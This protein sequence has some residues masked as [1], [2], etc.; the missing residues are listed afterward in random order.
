MSDLEADYLTT[1]QKEKCQKCLR[2][3]E[4]I[5]ICVCVLTH[6]KI[7]NLI[8]SYLHLQSTDIWSFRN[9]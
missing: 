4:V 6:V 2:P 9:P 5:I 1:E 3:K 8:P 7:K